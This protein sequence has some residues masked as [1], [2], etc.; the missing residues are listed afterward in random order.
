MCECEIRHVVGVTSPIIILTRC[1]RKRL[2]INFRISETFPFPFYTHKF[3]KFSPHSLRSLACLVAAFGPFHV[4]W[5]NVFSKLAP[6]PPSENPGYGPGCPE[7]KSGGKILVREKSF[8]E[9]VRK[10][11]PCP[12]LSWSFGSEHPPPPS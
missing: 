10:W 5:F 9:I 12:V 2:S 1:P 7:K 6:P 3:K 11:P 4:L 8:G